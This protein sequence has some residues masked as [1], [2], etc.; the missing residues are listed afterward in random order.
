MELEMVVHIIKVYNY[1]NNKVNV[2]EHENNR[3]HQNNKMTGNAILYSEMTVEVK[4]RFFALTGLS[5]LRDI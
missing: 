4:T 3:Q 5:F 2:G 1:S